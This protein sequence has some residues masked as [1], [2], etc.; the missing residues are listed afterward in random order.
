MSTFIQNLFFRNATV[1]VNVITTSS[2][3]AEAVLDQV[4]NGIFRLQNGTKATDRPQQLAGQPCL[5]YDSSDEDDFPRPGQLRAAYEKRLKDEKD[6]E[7]RRERDYERRIL[8]TAMPAIKAKLKRVSACGTTLTIE[9]G[10][11]MPG[12]VFD[13][14]YGG[15]SRRDRKKHAAEVLRA[16]LRELGW[17]VTVEAGDP[18]RSHGNKNGGVCA[19]CNA[20][21]DVKL[22]FSW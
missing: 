22:N 18:C 10:T 5:S 15:C 9:I 16:K 20:Y 2:A 13:S 14:K 21:E 4:G 19:K 1:N 11:V 3:E 6:E 12:F 17:I 8:D 7:V